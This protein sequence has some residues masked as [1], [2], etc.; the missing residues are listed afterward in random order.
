MSETR[1][2]DY[3]KAEQKSDVLFVVEGKTI[4][5]LK[6]FNSQTRVKYS[7]LCFL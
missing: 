1:E 3:L 7:V 6:S 4:R 5:G 2:L